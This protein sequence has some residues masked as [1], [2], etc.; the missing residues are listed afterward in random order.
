M[1]CY[2]I[3]AKQGKQYYAPHTKHDWTDAVL[4]GKWVTV[5]GR[6]R[7]CGRGLHAARG[8]R[9]ALNFWLEMYNSYSVVV[10]EAF[11]GKEF[12]GKRGDKICAKKM[13]IGKKVGELKP[14]TEKTRIRLL[15]KLFPQGGEKR[16]KIS[17]RA[18]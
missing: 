9:Q 13:R 10:F 7:M 8:I 15:N 6:L 12:V 5:K 1:K 16:K 18:W 4:T 2:K 3:L 11:T 14:W 17:R